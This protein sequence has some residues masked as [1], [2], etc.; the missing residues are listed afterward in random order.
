MTEE[1]TLDS[2]TDSTDTSLG[3]RGVGEGLGVLV[4][5]S[6]RDRKELDTTE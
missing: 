3:N 2:I 5:C 4:C 1:E 6:P